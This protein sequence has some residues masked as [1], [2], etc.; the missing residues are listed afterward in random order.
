MLYLHTRLHTKKN[1]RIRGRVADGH[2]KRV[3]R[4]SSA[5]AYVRR[6][7]CGITEDAERMHQC[8]ASEDEWRMGIK[9][10]FRVC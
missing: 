5:Y 2:Q 4:T 10:E 7:S 9:N 3:L 6:M 1:H 8:T